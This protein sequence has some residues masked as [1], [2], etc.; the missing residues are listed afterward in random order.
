MTTI[1]ISSGV[2]SSGLVIS[3]GSTLLVEDGGIVSASFVDGDETIS[4][5]GLSIDD[6]IHN[7]ASA[8]VFGSASGARVGIN[9]ELR[10]SSGGVATATTAVGGLVTVLS[11]GLA[12]DTHID[13]DGDFRSGFIE[14]VGSASGVLLEGYA[15]IE[16]YG[17]VVTNLRMVGGVDRPD[18][19]FVDGTAIDAKVSNALL[20]TE[21]DGRLSGATVYSGGEVHVGAV[22]GGGTAID[23]V[24]ESS[25]SLLADETGVASRTIAEAGSLVSVGLAGSAVDTFV[26]SAGVLSVASHGLSEG[27]RV[28]GGGLE[29]VDG[30]GATSG[31]YVLSGGGLDAGSGA[32]VSGLTV[33][34]GAAFHW[35]KGALV[36][37]LTI[38]T[39]ADIFLNATSAKA[40]ISAG[41]LYITSNN[42]S[43]ITSA[44]LVGGGAG[45]TLTSDTSSAGQTEFI[46]DKAAPLPETHP[47]LL[48]QSIAT[49][50]GVHGIA[51][52]TSAHSAQLTSAAAEM[53][54][55][56]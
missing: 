3:K 35:S 10:V 14:V 44:P 56:R 40:T 29:L 6:S 30:A 32:S 12:V 55:P 22:V 16:I 15:A 45:F 34:G 9:G 7:E 49:F 54:K 17:G 50:G 31:D 41:D 53:L 38:H 46:V 51:G 2:T 13:G 48:A 33:S 23:V 19:G 28:S 52:G 42:G 27:A 25:G 43:A 5:G 39:G 20:N 1:T 4:A 8:T 36:G 21:G 24:V 11:G 47:A 37:D 18:S 26:R